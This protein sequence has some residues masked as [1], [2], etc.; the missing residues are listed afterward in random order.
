MTSASVKAIM[1]KRSTI[2]ADAVN[3]RVKFFIQ[4]NGNIV[5]VKDKDG[6]PVPSTIPGYEGTVLQKKI[7][8]LRANSAI[9]MQNVRNRQYLK[10][11]LAAEKAGGTITVERDGKQ[12]EATAHELFNSYLNAVQM[13]LGILVPNNIADKLTQGT[14]IAGTVV[15]IDTPNGSL[16]TVDPSTISIVEPESY[17]T[18]TFD[19]SDFMDEAAAP[20]EALSTETAKV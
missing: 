1:Q 19:L 14:E 16:L 11:A 2:P 3:K 17:G 18:V 20:A 15:K 4:G 6:I 10:D 5:D 12:V 7:F 13:S 9:A 8:N